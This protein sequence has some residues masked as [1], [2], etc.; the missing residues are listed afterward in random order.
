MSVRMTRR[1]PGGRSGYDQTKPLPPTRKSKPSL[2]ISTTSASDSAMRRTSSA[3]ATS[4]HPRIE[5][6][7]RLHEIPHRRAARHVADRRRTRCRRALLRH[8]CGGLA[9]G[10]GGG[11]IGLIITVVVL[12]AGGGGG[13]GGGSSSDGQPA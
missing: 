11:I 2:S 7:E 12:L 5:W 3:S 9:I 8:S 13:G 6:V 1:L 10:G 4:D